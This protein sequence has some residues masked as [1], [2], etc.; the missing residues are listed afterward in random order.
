MGANV[1]RGEGETG[2][3]ASPCAGGGTRSSVCRS[4]TNST[5]F[6]V[7]PT[8]VQP[9]QPWHVCVCELACVS[10]LCWHR[11]VSVCT[12]LRDAQVCR[13]VC[14]VGE[15]WWVPGPWTAS[16]R[17]VLPAATTIPQVLLVSCCK[18]HL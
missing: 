8:G 14:G 5:A 17:Q 10:V 18:I 12:Q 7:A 9:P 16:P 4:G 2:R 13:R 3:Q 1:E 11:C 6:L 15:H